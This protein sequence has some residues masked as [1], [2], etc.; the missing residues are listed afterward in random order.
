MPILGDFSVTV[1]FE[2]LVT[3]HRP[4]GR[5]PSEVQIEALR[6]PVEEALAHLPGLIEPAVLY[7][8]FSL[9]RVADEK[10]FLSNGHVLSV[11]PLA[12]LLE[13]AEEILAAVCTIGP[14][15]E[16]AVNS[17]FDGD[18]MLSLMVD[19]AGVIALSHVGERAVDLAEQRA[20]S[21]N[22]GVSPALSPGSLPGWTLRS[23]RELTALLPIADIGVSLKDSNLLVPYKSV[24][25]VIGIGPGYREQEVG[26]MC[27]ICALKEHCWRRH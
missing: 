12:D 9:D 11:G 2:E 6:A 26:S 19:S 25:V 7:D 17:G 15:L 13:P 16:A 22:Q 18:A 3:A 14:R 1:T 8:V 20:V 21:K 10:A 27:H 5:E 23:Q 4:R 24:S